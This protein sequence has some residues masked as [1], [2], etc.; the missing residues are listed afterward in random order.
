MAAFLEYEDSVAFRA[1]QRAKTVDGERRFGLQIP[2]LQNPGDAVGDG[3]DL[4]AS[5]RAEHRHFS[6]DTFDLLDDIVHCDA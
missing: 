1:A 5:R 2:V 4:T 3:S 6:A